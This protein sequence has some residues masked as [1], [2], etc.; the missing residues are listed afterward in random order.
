M[1]SKMPTEFFFGSSD[2]L[3]YRINAISKLQLRKSA[4]LGGSPRILFQLSK[5]LLYD[6]VTDVRLYLENPFI[7][8]YI[9]SNTNDGRFLFRKK[10]NSRSK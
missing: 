10:Y 7:D 4:G 3:L 1:Y 6:L 5:F 2:C 9:L 8:I